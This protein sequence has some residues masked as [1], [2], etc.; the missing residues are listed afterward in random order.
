MPLMEQLR[1]I[2]DICIGD[3]EPYS[4][5]HPHDFTVDHHAE[6]AG[7]PHVGIEVRQDLVRDEPGARQWAAILAGALAGVLADANLYR[8]LQDTEPLEPQR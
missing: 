8:R 7:L 4:G 6:A 5:R 2:P 1:G 3:N